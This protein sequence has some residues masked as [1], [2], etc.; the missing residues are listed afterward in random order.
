MLSFVRME[1]CLERGGI[2][3]LEPRFVVEISF[4]IFG[5][6][7]LNQNLFLLKKR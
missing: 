4:D 3:C 2:Y 6:L 1:S 7:I 5:Y